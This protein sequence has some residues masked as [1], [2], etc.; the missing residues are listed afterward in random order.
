MNAWDVVYAL[1][2]L[3]ALGVILVT[4]A[5]DVAHLAQPTPGPRQPRIL[6][7]AALFSLVVLF[8]VAAALR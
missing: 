4:I 6:A 7:A 1:A 3:A 2:G 5:D 8:L